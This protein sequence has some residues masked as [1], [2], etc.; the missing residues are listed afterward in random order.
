MKCNWCLFILTAAWTVLLKVIGWSAKLQYC[1]KWLN[2]LK[3]CHH[4]VA[5]CMKKNHDFQPTTY[6]NLKIVQNGDM[7]TIADK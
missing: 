2:L 4:P 6:S 3:F 1:V 5:P 7:A